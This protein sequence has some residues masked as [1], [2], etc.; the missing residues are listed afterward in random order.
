MPRQKMSPKTV[1]ARLRERQAAELRMAGVTYQDIAE[2]LGYAGKSGA[3]KAV[4]RFLK[5]LGPSEDV[6]TLRRLAHARY[7]RMLMSLWADATSQDP[8]L[9][10]QAAVRKII[11]EER[12]LLGIDVP[13]E[14]VHTVGGPLNIRVLWR[15]DMERL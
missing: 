9:A 4:V 7:E 12:K 5:R 14:A 2:R 8:D 1:R 6:E 15:E 11:R 10:A 13:E 3:Y